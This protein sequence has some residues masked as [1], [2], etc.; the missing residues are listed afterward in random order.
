MGSIA[1]SGS[2]KFVCNQR[3][4][5]LFH[6]SDDE[7]ADPEE[8]ANAILTSE[9][10]T[11]VAAALVFRKSRLFILPPKLIIGLALLSLESDS[12]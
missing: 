11:A 3:I 1:A 4:A 12:P 6:Q 5:L 2:R 8:L 7:V 9:N 10:A